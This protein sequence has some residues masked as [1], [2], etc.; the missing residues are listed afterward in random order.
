MMGM[1]GSLFNASR[2][3]VDLPA[4]LSGATGSIATRE[5]AFAPI[6]CGFFWCDIC[7][8]VAVVGLP[9]RPSPLPSPGVPGEGENAFGAHAVGKFSSRDPAM[10]FAAVWRAYRASARGVA[11]HSQRAAYADFRAD[12]DGEDDRGL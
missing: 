7:A 12:G 4:R 1:A 11:A 2:T 3:A 9:R 10:V 6:I 5:G 8:R